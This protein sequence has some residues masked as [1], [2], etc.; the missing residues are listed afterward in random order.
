MLKT[1]SLRAELSAAGMFER[2]EGRTWAKFAFLMS[3][4]AGLMVA[5][6]YLPFWWSAL[7]TPVTAWFCAVAAMIGHEGSHRG[8]S[9]EPWR[10]RLIFNLTFPVLGG[11]SGP[12]WHWKHD[13]QHAGEKVYFQFST[14]FFGSS[15]AY[16]TYC[17]TMT[18]FGVFSYSSEWT[19]VNRHS[20][21]TKSIS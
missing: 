21:T 19:Q 18:E 7:L 2:C 20:A 9:S 12:Y 13:I 16:I 11:V 8:L 5:H 3:I 6:V 1:K 10:N 14:F 17:T 15:W 4:V